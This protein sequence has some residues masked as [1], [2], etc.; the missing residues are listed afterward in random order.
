MW[1]TA[2]PVAIIAAPKGIQLESVAIAF[3]PTNTAIKPAFTP[4]AHRYRMAL[5]ALGQNHFVR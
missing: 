4:V 5:T 1:P 2:R 3:V